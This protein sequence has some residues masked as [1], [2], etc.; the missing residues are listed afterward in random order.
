M[1]KD[2]LVRVRPFG[3]F[4]TSDILDCFLIASPRVGSFPTARTGIKNA[5]KRL[6]D[7]S[8]GMVP[9]VRD[10][11]HLLVLLT[12]EAEYAMFSAVATIGLATKPLRDYSE[13]RAFSNIC[14]P[15]KAK[16]QKTEVWSDSVNDAVHKHFS[17]ISA[18]KVTLKSAPSFRKKGHDYCEDMLEMVARIVLRP[19]LT[20]FAKSLEQVLGWQSI[21]KSGILEYVDL[22]PKIQ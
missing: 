6:R 5:L 14:L 9:I 17:A 3:S 11:E 22:K 13:Y 1:Q 2:R 21:E 19:S 10:V 4:K 15:T 7:L 12:Q 8:Y 16:D 18:L 20:K